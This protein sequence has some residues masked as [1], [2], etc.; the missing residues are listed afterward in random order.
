M[1][2]F[3]PEYREDEER[4]ADFCRKKLVYLFLEMMARFT[5]GT[6]LAKSNAE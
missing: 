4:Q 3:L 2:V 5:N 1:A 6:I